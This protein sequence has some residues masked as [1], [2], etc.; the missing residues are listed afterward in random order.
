MANDKGIDYGKSQDTGTSGSSK[1]AGKASSK[2]ANGMADSRPSCSDGNY[3]Q[4]PH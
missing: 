1:P 4:A 3:G 2:D